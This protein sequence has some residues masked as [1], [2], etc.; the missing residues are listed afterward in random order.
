[1]YCIEIIIYYKHQMSI[2]LN[3]INYE[4]HAVKRNRDAWWFERQVKIYPW[5]QPDCLRCHYLLILEYPVETIYNL[6]Q[7]YQE[8]LGSKRKLRSTLKPER[9]KSKQEGK[10]KVD[11]WHTF[12]TAHRVKKFKRIALYLLWTENGQLLRNYNYG[13]TKIDQYQLTIKSVGRFLMVGTFIKLI[14]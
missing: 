1:M 3:D 14:Y 11:R 12:Y 2:V 13:P 8:F 6:L 10:A 4:G 9:T 7:R 5:H